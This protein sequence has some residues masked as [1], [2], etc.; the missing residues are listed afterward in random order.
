MIAELNG[1]TRPIMRHRRGVIWCP[2][3]DRSKQDEGMEQSCDGCGA[4][5]ADD[6]IEAAPEAAEPAP[7]R[8]KQ[9]RT[10]E[11]PEG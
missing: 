8:R 3:C 11:E 2:F 10:E 5:F 6:A 9:A 7:R 1:E 4:C